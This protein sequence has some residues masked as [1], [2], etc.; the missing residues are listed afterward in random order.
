MKPGPR[1]LPSFPEKQ[2]SRVVRDLER[3][4]VQVW[5]SSP[6]T[7]IDSHGVEAG[8]E[9]V[10]AATVLWA[11]GVKANDLAKSLELPLDRQGRLLVDTYLHPV[12]FNE[13][14]V[15]GDVAHCNNEAGEALPGMA[16]VAIQQGRYIARAIRKDLKNLNPKPFIYRDK[17][18]MATIGRSR[19]IVNANGLRYGGW[20]AWLTWLIV[21]IYFLVGFKNRLFVV[22]QWAWA[23]LTFRRG[24][25]IIL[26]PRGQDADQQTT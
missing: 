8:K 5:V 6:V 11:A 3:L 22:M 18:Q 17:G 16:P 24:A 15:A 23:Y 13:V 21:H 14:F 9:R 2:A 26:K 1:I 7:R 25:R 12:G 4:G 10:E 19:A 20:L